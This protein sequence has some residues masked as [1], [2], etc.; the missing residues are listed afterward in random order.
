MRY[1]IVDPYPSIAGRSSGDTP[2]DFSRELPME[3]SN[4]FHRG[5]PSH[6]PFLDGIFRERNHLFWVSPYLWKPPLIGMI[7]AVV[8]DMFVEKNHTS[9]SDLSTWV[10]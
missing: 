2:A 10:S 9:S 4:G 6:D 3:V 1:R 8:G 7:A 5:T